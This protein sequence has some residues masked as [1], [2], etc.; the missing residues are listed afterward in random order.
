MRLQRR[1]RRAHRQVKFQGLLLRGARGKCLLP[2]PPS[3]KAI[4]SDK[5]KD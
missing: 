1:L 2:L 5:P 3:S 4:P